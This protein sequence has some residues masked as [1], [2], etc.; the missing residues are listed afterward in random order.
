MVDERLDELSE[1]L[2]VRPQ[3]LGAGSE[4]RAGQP[5]VAEMELGRLGEPLEPVAV[6]GL[7][8]LQ[9]EQSLQQGQI[10]A[11]R[12]E[13]ELERRREAAHVEQAPGVGCGRLQQ[14]RHGIEPRD[15]GQVPHIALGDG[16]EVVGVPPGPSPSGRPGQGCR[17]PACRDPIPQL[18]SQPFV[19]RHFEATIEQG[20]EEPP[21]GPGTVAGTAGVDELGLRQGVQPQN[22]HATGERVRQR[23]HQQDVGRAGQHK[24]PGPAVAVDRKLD[25][26]EQIRHSLNFVEH[27]SPGQVG[28]ETGRIGPGRVAG[29]VV[30]EGD[31]GVSEP[32]RGPRRRPAAA[33]EVLR[34]AHRLRQRG[35][36]ALARAVDE[37]RRRV[38]ER[39]EEPP[40]NMTRVE[41][42]AAHRP[43]VTLWVG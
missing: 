9:Q 18:R 19:R 12:R 14:P 20:V 4:Q 31:V 42:A 23:R 39:L 17:I 30:V 40:M 27:H 13:A 26:R 15:A 10:I 43:I 24:A 16:V 8:A 28:H 3:R 36:A 29:R 22:L 35:L 6:P 37:H 32:G 1:Q 2:P 5:R 11:D 21:A 38:L 25:R 7:Q 34:S 33:D 41:H